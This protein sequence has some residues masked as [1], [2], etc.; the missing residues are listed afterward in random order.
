[1]TTSDHRYEK[2]VSAS[3]VLAL[4]LLASVAA[5][6]QDAPPAPTPEPIDVD[7]LVRRP[8]G[9]DRAQLELRRVVPEG[10]DGARQAVTPEGETIYLASDVIVTERDVTEAHVTLEPNLVQYAVTLHFNQAAAT[11]LEHATSS[12]D[13]SFG[14]RLAIL[15]NG[16]VLAAPTV[17]SRLSD[18][19]MFSGHY[20]RAAAR[21]LA[22]QLAP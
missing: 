2:H 19:A 14:M 9:V 6:A 8:E 13:G 17:M 1:M 20:T 4:L 15:L 12:S 5:G 18:S 16:Q 11:R 10:K 3:A 21:R 22:E 7:V